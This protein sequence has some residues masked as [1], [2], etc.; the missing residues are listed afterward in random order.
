M[1]IFKSY[2]EENVLELF[3]LSK[4]KKAG[5]NQTIYSTGNNN[6]DNVYFVKKGEF[7]V[8]YRKLLAKI[9]FKDISEY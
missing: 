3:D 8:K 9:Y 2:P 7:K 1:N 6:I 4:E 5:M